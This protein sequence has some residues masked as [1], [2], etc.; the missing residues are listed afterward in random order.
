L[1]RARAGNPLFLVPE[2]GDVEEVGQRMTAENFPKFL[3]PA[4]RS[5]TIFSGS[6]SLDTADNKAS[7]SAPIKR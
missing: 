6:S 3:T 4:W 5:T 1:Q 2:A 7:R